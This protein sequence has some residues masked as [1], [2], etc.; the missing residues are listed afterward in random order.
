MKPIKLQVVS[1]RGVEA[2]ISSDGSQAGVEDY[3]AVVSVEGFVEEKRV[4]G[5]DPIQSFSLGLG[6]IEQLTETMRI[7]ADDEEPVPGASWRIEV[8]EE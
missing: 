5:I 4:Y 1:D 8:V 6:L 2:T 3:Y 7:G